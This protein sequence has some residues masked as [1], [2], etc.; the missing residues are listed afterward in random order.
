MGCKKMGHWGY[1]EMVLAAQSQLAPAETMPLIVSFLLWE[2]FPLLVA[3]WMIPAR[4][5]R[6][7]RLLATN[8]V[9]GLIPPMLGAER[10]LG[11]LVTLGV[12]F[13]AVCASVRVDA[14]GAVPHPRARFLQLLERLLKLHE[15]DLPNG[16]WG[17]GYA[18]AEASV[19]GAGEKR[20]A[21]P[22][23]SLSSRLHK[24]AA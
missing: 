19:Q 14:G 2:I 21:C 5:R 15:V 12:A 10:V 13:K 11:A 8:K 17:E 16:R 9:Q 6:D 20:V 22:E 3:C 18:C 23:P 24:A 1:W 7:G 4:R